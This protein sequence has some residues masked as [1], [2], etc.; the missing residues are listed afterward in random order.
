MR[1][2]VQLRY[3][4]GGGEQRWARSAYLDSTSRHIDVPLDA[5]VPVDRQTGPPPPIAQ[6][7]SLMFV[8][9]LVNASPGASGTFRIANV[10]IAR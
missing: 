2:S 9:D 5:M 10:A 4:V 3:P 6:A 8:V 7:R 1:I